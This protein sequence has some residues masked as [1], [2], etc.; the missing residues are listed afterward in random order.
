MNAAPRDHALAIWQAAVAAARPDD[1]LRIALSEPALRA[2]IEQ[3]R[4]LSVVGGG[5]AGAAMSAAVESLLAGRLEHIEGIVNVPAEVVR[6][7][8]RIRLHAARPAGANQPTVEGVAG[9]REILRLVRSAGPEDVVL[10]V[11]SGGG[12][13]L[14]PAP[15]AGVPLE[16]KQ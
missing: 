11:L 2:A 5:K 14:L 1:L 12:S 13:A 4:R 9:T 8:Q 10:C 7:L 3:A 15:V 16:D 6:P